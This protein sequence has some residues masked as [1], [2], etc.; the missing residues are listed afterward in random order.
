MVYETEEANGLDATNNSLTMS[1]LPLSK[2]LIASQIAQPSLRLDRSRRYRLSRYDPDFQEAEPYNCRKELYWLARSHTILH[3]NHTTTRSHD[4]SGID[5]NFVRY[6][7]GKRTGR[8]AVYYSYIQKIAAC[9][10]TSKIS[11]Y[12]ALIHGR[13]MI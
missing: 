8:S 7:T 5:R 4:F 10:T 9:W 6:G 13:S 3:A 11:C 12:T 2:P 1:G